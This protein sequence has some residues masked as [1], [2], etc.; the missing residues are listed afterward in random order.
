MQKRFEEFTYIFLVNAGQMAYLEEAR[1]T[2]SMLQK[3]NE[4][5]RH[6]IK[7]DKLVLFSHEL[8]A[9]N[10]YIDI[11][12]IRYVNRFN[13]SLANCESYGDIFINH[14]S[15]ID[16]FD[17]ILENAMTKYENHMDFYLEIETQSVLKLKI[18]LKAEKQEEVYYQP[19][20]GEGN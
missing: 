5:F 11:L 13:V 4:L 14:M 12:K 17:K 15:I 8:A 18:V 1:G 20:V 16:F 2:Y 10:N 9:F 7:D 3:F 6:I 19:L